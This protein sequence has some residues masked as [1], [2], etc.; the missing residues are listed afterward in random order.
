MAA[1]FVLVAALAVSVKT[2]SYGVWEIKRKN[3]AGGVFA[4]LISV[5][6]VAQAVRYLIEYWY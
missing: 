2:A 3:G 6:C 1:V 5:L 4:I